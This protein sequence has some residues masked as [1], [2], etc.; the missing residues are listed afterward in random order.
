MQRRRIVI[1]DDEDEIVKLIQGELGSEFR[2]IHFK[3]AKQLL[4]F[5]DNE[6]YPTKDTFLL[7]DIILG[8]DDSGGFTVVKELTDAGIFLP[9]I[10]VSNSR[11]ESDIQKAA[12]VGSSAFLNKLK[13]QT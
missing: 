6:E 8:E 1:L 3:E 11:L 7:V 12:E 2:I 5:V 4:E 13:L 10:F 9:V